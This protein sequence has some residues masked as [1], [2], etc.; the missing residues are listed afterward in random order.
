M[1]LRWI[2]LVF[3]AHALGETAAVARQPASPVRRGETPAK[4]DRVRF[5][6]SIICNPVDSDGKA[7]PVPPNEFCHPPHAWCA[8]YDY[9]FTSEAPQDKVDECKRRCGCS[10][11]SRAMRYE[12]LEH[13]YD[14]GEQRRPRRPALGRWYKADEVNKALDGA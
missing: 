14:P 5:P 4:A 9:R 13:N 12:S 1:R 8:N 7:V 6:L 11:M 10:H 3:I 2:L